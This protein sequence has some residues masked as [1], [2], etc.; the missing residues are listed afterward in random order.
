MVALNTLLLVGG[1]AAA[2]GVVATIAL[3]LLL[4]IY[5]GIKE[6]KKK[7]SACDDDEGGIYTIPMPGMGGGA[8]TITQADIDQARH[9]IMQHRQGQGQGVPGE[10][11]KEETPKI[12]TYL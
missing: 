11:K 12:G 4:G 5:L 7:A 3:L 8:R 1:L 2:A 9:A 6:I 10:E